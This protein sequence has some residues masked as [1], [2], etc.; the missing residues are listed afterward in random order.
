MNKSLGNCG[1]YDDCKS[2][3]CYGCKS[4]AQC[5]SCID[6]TGSMSMSDDPYSNY[7]ESC[8]EFGPAIKANIVATQKN[9]NKPINVE[10]NYFKDDM[11][12]RHARS[13]SKLSEAGKNDIIEK[14]K[15]RNSKYI[16]KDFNSYQTA[17]QDEIEKAIFEMIKIATCDDLLPWNMELIRDVSD[18]VC[19]VLSKKGYLIYYPNTTEDENGNF[20]ISDFYGI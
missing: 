16:D 13:F 7:K 20:S 1:H 3:K 18:A 14:I 15:I 9:E 19:D 2:C 12:R 10:T 8:D 11:C 5:K 4:T 17:R 6:C